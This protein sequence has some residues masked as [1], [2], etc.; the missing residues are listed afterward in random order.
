[1]SKKIN[2]GDTIA[3]V[4]VIETVKIQYTS[5]AVNGLKVLHD[6]GKHACGGE[7]IYRIDYLLGLEK[8][9][10]KIKFCKNC[11]A[12]GP[13]TKGQTARD[14][15]DRE[16]DNLLIMRNS[17]ALQMVDEHMPAQRNS[18]MWCDRAAV[19]F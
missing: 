7:S 13:Y 2:P 10:K 16:A 1:M 4:T 11:R 5:C 19:R 14:I 6:I 15:G 18:F 3:G 9:G 17:S 12:R 8:Q